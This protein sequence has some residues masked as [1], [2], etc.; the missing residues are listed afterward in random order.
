MYTCQKQEKEYEKGPTKKLV[1]V[2]WIYS[3]RLI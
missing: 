1:L 2:N 3:L